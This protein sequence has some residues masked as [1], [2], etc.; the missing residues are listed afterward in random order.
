[1]ALG[2]EY[3]LE[4]GGTLTGSSVLANDTDAED[5]DSEDSETNSEAEDSDLESDD[6]CP[7][8]NWRRRRDMVSSVEHWSYTPSQMFP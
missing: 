6:D 8:K 3:V 7:W 4:E 1:M 2:D 5:T